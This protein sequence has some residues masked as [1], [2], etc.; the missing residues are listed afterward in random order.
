MKTIKKHPSQERLRELFDYRDGKLIWKV[1][2]QRIKIGDVFG[3]PE[4]SGYLRGCVDGVEFKVH[5]LIWVWHHGDIPEGLVIDHQNEIKADNR[6][7][8]LKPMRPRENSYRGKRPGMKNI[9]KIGK[10]WMVQFTI[11][12]KLK[13]FGTYDTIPE[14]QA[15]RDKKLSE[16]NKQENS[17]G[18]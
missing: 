9:Y 7:E 14:A 17:Q 12:G 15:A 8:N 2:R 3:G 11:D 5:R 10:G 4:A 18:D 1:R 16:I 6:I 13:Y